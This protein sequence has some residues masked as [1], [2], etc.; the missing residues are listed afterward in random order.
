MNAQMQF[1]KV[2]L[3]SNKAVCEPVYENSLKIVCPK[4]ATCG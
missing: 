1:L 4:G 2:M 3:D